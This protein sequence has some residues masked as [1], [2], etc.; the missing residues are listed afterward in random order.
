MKRKL[1][2][3]ELNK[4]VEIL[5]EI[6]DKSVAE[7]EARIREIRT[8][9][10]AIAGELDALIRKTDGNE[11]LEKSP[12]QIVEDAS[13]TDELHFEEGETLGEY[14]I[15]RV[16]GKGGFA[17]VYLADHIPLGRE[18][19]L[20]VSKDSGREARTLAQ[21]EH[22]FI[23]SVYS[24]TSDPQKKLRWISM[25]FIPG[26]P[27][28]GIQSRLPAEQFTGKGILGV[29]D[30]QTTAKLTFDP[31]QAEMRKTIAGFDKVDAVLWIGYKLAEAL[32]YAH[33]RGILH[34]DV[35]PSNI[36]LNRYGRP[37]LTDFNISL[38]Q[39]VEMSDNI[40]QFG[41]TWK[42]MSPEQQDVFYAKDRVKALQ[43][44]DHRADIY[45]LAYVMKE[46][47]MGVTLSK[48]IET[49]LEIA[50]DPLTRNRFATTEDFVAQLRACIELKGVESKLPRKGKITEFAEKYPLIAITLVGAVPQII[51]SGVGIVY[52]FTRIV[53]QLTPAQ[54]GLFIWL[55]QIITPAFY[56]VATGFWVFLCYGLV[57]Y[58]NNPK[59]YFSRQNDVIGMKER[60]L[61]LPFWGAVVTVICWFVTSIVFPVVINIQAG[62]IEI[63]TIAHFFFSFL[64]SSLI[65][66]SYTY[67]FHL[68]L[69]L[70]VIYPRVLVASPVIREASKEDL[71]RLGKGLKLSLAMILLIP[72]IAAIILLSLGA[73]EI[74]GSSGTT[75]RLLSVSLISFGIAGLLFALSVGQKIVGMIVTYTRG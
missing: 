67:L 52:N 51:A 58:L 65:A 13:V 37:Y 27:L 11:F 63:H 59:S 31:N 6:S 62:P 49:V 64:L 4:V 57:D 48:K 21:L 44:I 38:D 66:L 8:T 55:N 15:K 12:L 3:A 46:L 24:E 2:I 26:L 36:L 41:G 16:L 23:V 18:V 56:P 35:K 70:R 34:L 50:L 33:A 60:A 30:K 74:V 25:Q 40:K 42:Y 68:Y 73:E 39:Q 19:A 17:T 45:S 75:F 47:L 5:E 9:N 14:K 29:L 53:N 69:T 10:E 22:D 54:R 1:S 43:A 20:K 61:N 7:Q 28:D 32:A 72:N 71:K